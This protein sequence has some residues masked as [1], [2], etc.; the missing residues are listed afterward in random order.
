MQQ[1]RVIT[2]RRGG[3]LG[4]LGQILLVYGV[5]PLMAGPCPGARGPA[6]P[7]L[8]PGRAHASRQ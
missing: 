2:A 8:F 1:Q 7:P 4:I 5:V 3:L 6:R